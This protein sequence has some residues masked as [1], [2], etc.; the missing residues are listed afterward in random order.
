MNITI[1][2]PHFGKASVCEPILRAL[3]DWFGI[4]EAIILYQAEI[5]HLPTILAWE[6]GNVIG[7]L[8]IKQHN[9]YSAEVYVMGIRAEAHRHGIGR[10]LI[11]KA[12]EWLRAQHVELTGQDVGAFEP[13]RKLRQDQELLQ[14]NGLQTI[15]GVQADMG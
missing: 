8:S 15:G 12:Q 4:E 7:F 11:D 14:R 5:E 6:T 13:G 2:G 9:A 10:A 1:D 3:P